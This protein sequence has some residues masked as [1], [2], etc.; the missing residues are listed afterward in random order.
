MIQTPTIPSMRNTKLK[1]IKR[2]G[3]MVLQRQR[4]FTAA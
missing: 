1:I 4:P 3:K 2:R